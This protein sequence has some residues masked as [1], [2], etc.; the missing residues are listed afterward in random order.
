MLIVFDGPNCSG[1]TTLIK[2]VYELLCEEFSTYLTSEPTRDEFGE[3]VRNNQ[4]N[5]DPLS[6]LYLIIANRAHHVYTEI[7]PNRNKIILCDRYIPSSLALQQSKKISLDYIWELNKTFIKPDITFFLS[8]SI[9]NLNKRLQIREKKSYVE[10]NYTRKK[11]VKLFK[12]AFNY[13][14]HKTDNVYWLE[15]DDNTQ[16]L[17][18]IIETIRKRIMQNE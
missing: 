3:F 6:Y 13:M 14:K 7:M 5:L 4:A 18:F 12:S 16:N 15:N 11:E 17:V 2:K 9:E 8:A 10:K 1:K